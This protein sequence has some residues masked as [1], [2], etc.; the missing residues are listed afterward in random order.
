MISACSD[1]HILRQHLSGCFLRA[2]FHYIY[3]TFRGKKCSIKW[4]IKHT[5]NKEEK[6][7]PLGSTEFF[8]NSKGFRD[9]GA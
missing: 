6:L 5:M 3:T 8:S 1:K 9:G 7:K 2:I 4:K